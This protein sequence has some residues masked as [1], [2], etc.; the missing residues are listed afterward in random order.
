MSEAKKDLGIAARKDI[1]IYSQLPMN[2]Q[3]VFDDGRKKEV[4]STLTKD[5]S[6]G[7]VLFESNEVLPIDASIKLTLSLPGVG[8]NI[9]ALSN[10]VRVEE[11]EFKRQ[12]NI[13][14]EFKEIKEEDREEILKRISHLDIVRILDIAVE[15]GASDVHL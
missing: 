10:I 8:H 6:S 4:V 3:V 11:I 7:G 9:E 2:Y 13:G 15:K 5:I 1:R 14:V 12:Y